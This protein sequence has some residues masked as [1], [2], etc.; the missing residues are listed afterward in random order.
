[1][2]SELD[3]KVAP[4][5]YYVYRTLTKRERRDEELAVEIGRVHR[6]NYG[7]YGARKVCPQLKRGTRP[8]GSLHGGAAHARARTAWSRP[9]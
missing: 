4:S 6:E 9:Q 2:L 8:G 3:V 7:A 1:V 5:T